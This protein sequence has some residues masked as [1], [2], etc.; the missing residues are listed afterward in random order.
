M[1]R[2]SW[3]TAP[4]L[5][6]AS[7]RDQPGRGRHGYPLSLFVA[8]TFNAH[9]LA[10]VGD[11]AHVLHPL[12]GLGFNLACATWL[13]LAETLH[14]AAALGLDIGSEAVLDRYTLWR[15]FDTVATAAA[16]DGMNRLF[17][18]DNAALR[19]V[20]SAGLLAVNRFGRAEVDAGHRSGRQVRAV[21]KLLRGEAI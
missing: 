5:R 16:M 13:Q 20:R 18:N 17:A 8:E 2:A 3:R 10:L 1:T 6:R 19:L 4:P 21:P 14:D 9:R 15:R 7:G 12:A 11:A